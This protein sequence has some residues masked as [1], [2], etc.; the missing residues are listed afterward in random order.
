MEN[1]QIWVKSEEYIGYVTR[2]SKYVALLTA[3]RNVLQLD[4]NASGTKSYV[5]MAT[6]MGLILLTATCGSETV[7]TQHVDSG[8]GN[9]RHCNVVRTLSALFSQYFSFPLSVSFHHC[10][11]HIFFYRRTNGRSL[12]IFQRH[13]GCSS[14]NRGHARNTIHIFIVSSIAFA[15]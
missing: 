9:A 3:V 15:K 14:R 11:M 1:L 7:E 4:N 10:P 8:Y 5:S 13:R 12:G 6:L 2:T